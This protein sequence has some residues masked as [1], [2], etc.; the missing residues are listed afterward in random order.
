MRV[1]LVAPIYLNLNCCLV[2]TEIMPEFRGHIAQYLL[3]APHTLFADTHV[4]TTRQNARSDCPH[5][6]IM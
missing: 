5:L 3:S 2:S 4:T 1:A 6:Q